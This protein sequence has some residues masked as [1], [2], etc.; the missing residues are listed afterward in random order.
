MSIQKDL[1]IRPETPADVDAIA[2]VTEAAFR[3][4]A[5]SSHTEQ[6]IVAALRAAHALTISLVA[7]IGGRVVGHIA[8][9]SVTISDGS[10]EW[11]G[12]GPVSVLPELQ[13]QGIGSALVREG[14]ALLQ[15][16]DARGCCLVGHPEYYRRFGF[17]NT[18]ALGYE[19]VPLEF[20]FALSFEGQMPHGTVQFHE[21]F[22]AAGPSGT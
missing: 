7:E 11:Y 10:P 12:L 14:L 21:A 13:R 17:E 15:A 2:A 19:G 20:F 9:S 3:T 16:M 5:I 22:Q 6:F 4:L 1:L 8:F 18:P